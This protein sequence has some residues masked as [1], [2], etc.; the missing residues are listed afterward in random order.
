MSQTV[1]EVLILR[2]GAG[3]VEIN[4]LYTVLRYKSR[5]ILSGTADK[6]YV[7][8]T[9]AFDFFAGKENYISFL[10]HGDEVYIWVPLGDFSNKLP[11]TAAYFHSHDIAVA[12]NFTKA[13]HITV[14][15]SDA[16]IPLLNFY[17][18]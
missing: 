5:Q 11:F 7:F 9:S 1:L 18:Y 3:E 15:G 13:K 8:N 10:L 2:E 12:E 14:L 17:I 4:K 16:E 6:A